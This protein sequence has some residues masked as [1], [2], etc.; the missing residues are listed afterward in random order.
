MKNF[1]KEH[2]LWVLFAAAVIAVA[3][4]VMSFFSSSTSS[5]LENLAGIITSPFRTA[6]SSVANWFNDKQDYF[7]NNQALREE[8]QELRNQIAQM[9]A[10]LR[11]AKSDSEENKRLRELLNLREKKRDL[12][13]LEPAQILEHSSSNWT[14]TLTLNQGTEHGVELN[15]CVITEEGY[16]VGVVNQVGLNWCTVLTVVDTDISLGAQVFRTEDVGVAEGDFSLMSQGRLKLSYLPA[17]VS[18]LNGDLI[19]TS[20]LGG[21]YPSGLVIGT[22]EEVQLDD[23]GSTQY[24]VIA[25]SAD[26]DSLTEVFIVKSFEIVN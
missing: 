24:A 20:G 14:S 3:L 12:G 9:E 26:L 2:G 15:D 4:A 5:P 19:V 6:F 18:L 7:A 23:S 11:Q 8:N 17:G 22:I 10:D 21:Y 25:P 1:L 13:E 16:L